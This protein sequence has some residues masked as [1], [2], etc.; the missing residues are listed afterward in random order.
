MEV[1]EQ[2]QQ[3][4]QKSSSFYPGHTL[5]VQT[6]WHIDILW[7]TYSISLIN[8]SSYF[9]THMYIIFSFLDESY[10]MCYIYLFLE[11]K[12]VIEETQEHKSFTYSV[13]SLKNNCL[14][15]LKL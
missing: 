12:R 15:S 4:L 1:E 3:F 7:L 8:E 11:F 2:S 10:T 5:N 14:T 6:W 13:P 9:L